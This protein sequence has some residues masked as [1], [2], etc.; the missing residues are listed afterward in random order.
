MTSCSSTQR[1]TAPPGR[2]VPGRHRISVSCAH[3]SPKK[4]RAASVGGNAVGG[5]TP[6][7]LARRPSSS[8]SSPSCARPKA[9]S[10]SGRGQP[11]PARGGPGHGGDGGD[12]PALAAGHDRGHPRA[13]GG[14]GGVRPERRGARRAQGG[15]GPRPPDEGEARALLQGGGGG[16]GLRPPG[17]VWGGGGTSLRPPQDPTPPSGPPPVVEA[18]RLCRPEAFPSPRVEVQGGLLLRRGEGGPGLHVWMAAAS[19]ARD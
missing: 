13:R 16:G 3:F 19:G 5:L 15:Q 10:R 14:G 8:S 18:S 6:P 7:H 17:E 4:A 9:P 11:P 12:V 2:V 1:R